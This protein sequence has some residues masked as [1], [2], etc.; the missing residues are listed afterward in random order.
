M[1]NRP[2]K[3]KVEPLGRS[4]N[5]YLPTGLLGT[6]MESGRTCEDEVNDFLTTNYGGFT[7]KSGANS[8]YWKDDDGK[9]YTGNM[10]H[11]QVAFEGKERIKPLEEFLAYLAIQLKQICIFLETGEDAWLVYP[12]QEESQTA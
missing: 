3:Y 8:G 11:Y 7:K 10:Q 1:I 2:V 9:I 4:A 12:Q 6:T 5:F